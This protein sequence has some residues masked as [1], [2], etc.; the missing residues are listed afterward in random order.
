[1]VLIAS[2]GP[3][4]TLD[5]PTHGVVLI[6]PYGRA[7][8]VGSL[9]DLLGYI[10]LA[11]L[12]VKYLLDHVVHAPPVLASTRAKDLV[13][14]AMGRLTLPPAERAALASPN[15]AVRRSRALNIDLKFDR[16][17]R[18]VAVSEDGKLVRRIGYPNWRGVLATEALPS[19]RRAS[20]R[21]VLSPNTDPVFNGGEQKFFVGIAREGTPMVL[22]SD[23]S[24]GC[25]GLEIIN[26][27]AGDSLT[28]TS[29]P[30]RGLLHY[31]FALS[32]ARS[33]DEIRASVQSEFQSAD[34]EVGDTGTLTWPH[35]GPQQWSPF[36]S[37]THGHI[38]QDPSRC[39]HIR[40]VEIA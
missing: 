18:Y 19:Q 27:H 31:T 20:W 39:S 15:T 1:V 29:D 14:D 9:D 24:D 17:P 37:M 40:V 23:S 5:P 6:E 34:E 3:H 35:A 4:S 28:F 22:D 33:V 16:R 2:C 30:E 25:I 7:L 32:G 36:V 10:S 38:S 21:L 12:G 26:P 11:E 8:A 13:R